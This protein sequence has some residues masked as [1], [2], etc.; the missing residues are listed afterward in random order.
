MKTAR[1]K[2]K[3]KRRKS[4]YILREASKRKLQ[5]ENSGVYK[6]IEAYLS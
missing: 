3:N 5:D 4:G 6:S 2:D 1:S